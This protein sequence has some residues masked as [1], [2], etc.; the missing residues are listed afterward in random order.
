MPKIT[1]SEI[2]QTRSYEYVSYDNIAYV[3]GFSAEPNFNPNSVNDGFVDSDALS[4]GAPPFVPV[5]CPDLDTFYKY[6]GSTAPTFAS[7][8]A[9]PQYIPASGGAAGVAGFDEKSVFGYNAEGPAPTMFKAGDEDPSYR[10]A[11]ELLT[12][13]VPVVYE[14]MNMF[15]TDT[16]IED[17][18]PTSVGT[19]GQFTQSGTNLYICTKSS[20]DSSAAE[21]ELVTSQS[22]YTAGSVTCD[23]TVSQMYTRLDYSFTV[24]S[25]SLTDR[26]EY[27]LSF[28]TSG[29]YPVFE[30]RDASGVCSLQSKMV[31][32]AT[33]RGDAVALI[34][35]TNNKYRPLSGDQS[36]FS[37][38][39]GTVGGV[40]SSFGA[41]FTPWCKYVE[42][43]SMLASGS[44]GYLMAVSRMMDS[45]TSDWLA[46]A[47][48]E[49]GAI[50]GVV[51]S[52]T[53]EKMTESIADSY[54][55]ANGVS[56]NPI[57]K[58]NPYGML[59]WGNRTLKSNN[60]YETALSFLN[61]RVLVNK[62]KKRVYSAA[63]ALMFEQNSDILWVNFKAQ[64]TP[65][66]DDMVSTA[67][68]SDFRIT[69]VATT[70]KTKV[71]AII[72][73][74]PVYA[75]EEFDITIKLTDSDVEI[76]E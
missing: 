35:H 34:D 50:P 29:G 14:R 4:H 3:P 25:T 66:L 76:E 46:V 13:G 60:G 8:Q 41:M 26:N 49:R 73:I 75:I 24:S 45:G 12:A 55:G 33:T 58:I 72:T 68:I 23:I 15:A 20:G 54:T 16:T 51:T 28:I 56:I 65:L 5:F 48:A 36:V 42:T 22:S 21:W 32:V 52:N 2:D 18:A 7:A 59:I 30:Y 38:I 62:L 67:G 1:I 44:F 9:Y 61:L 53:S 57:V 37:S 47:G 43:S 69:R 64:L 31:A 71:E 63:K 74:Y 11:V 6:F 40:N 19:Q 70:K 27:D 17:S 10:Y 39:N